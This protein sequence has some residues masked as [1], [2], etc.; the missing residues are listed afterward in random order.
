MS[1]R[2]WKEE[3]DCRLLSPDGRVFVVL[4]TRRAISVCVCVCVWH[5]CTDV[6][7]LAETA[8]DS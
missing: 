8:R 1:C 4:F 7:R 6:K 5:G 2:N 3:W